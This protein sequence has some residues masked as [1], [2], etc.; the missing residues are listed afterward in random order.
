M[1]CREKQMPC[2]FSCHRGSFARKQALSQEKRT[3]SAVPAFLYHKDNT[4]FTRKQIV[5]KSKKQLSHYE[6]AVNIKPAPVLTTQAD[7]MTKKICFAYFFSFSKSRISASNCSSL[8]GAGGSGVAAVSSS[9]FLDNF[10]T[11]FTIRNTQN[12]TMM[13]SKHV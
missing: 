7:F 13:K 1:A 4:F 5:L 11:S 6:T 9:F 10:I 2:S 12:A 3:V 8:D